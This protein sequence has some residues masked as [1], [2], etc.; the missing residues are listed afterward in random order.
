M[1][2]FERDLGVEQGRIAPSG[3]VPPEGTYV[4]VLGSDV[5]GRAFALMPGDGPYVTQA[6]SPD[7]SVVR[8][9]IRARGPAAGIPAQADSVPGPFALSDGDELTFEVG[10][11]PRTVTFT[12]DLFEDIATATAAEV[13]AA[14]A[15]QV[16]DAVAA[17]VLGFVRLATVATGRDA[18]LEVTGGAANAAL[19]F[20]TAAVTGATWVASLAID[21]ETVSF[22]LQ[23]GRTL[24]T[25]DVGVNASDGATGDLVIALELDGTGGPWEVE[26]PAVYI[27]SIVDE[28]PDSRPILMNRFPY[29]GEVGAPPTTLIRLDIADVD[30]G[31]DAAQGIDATQTQ[32][33]VD[34]VLAYDGG[35]F[36]P[37]FDGAG[38]VEDA[39][40]AGGLTLRLTIERAL[41]F[42]SEQIVPVRVVTR[43]TDGL[44]LDQ[45]YSFTVADTAAPLVDAAQAWTESSIRVRFSEA[46]R[47]SDPAAAD[48]ALNPSNWTVVLLAGPATDRADIA[49][50]AVDLAVV[51]VTPVSAT[52]VDV[53][54]DIPMTPNATY[55]VAAVGVSDVLGNVIA[56]PYHQATFLGFACPPPEGRDFQLWDMLPDLN[57]NEDQTGDLLKFVL[58]V[59][60]VVDL[61]LCRI[62]RLVDIFDPDLAPEGCVDHMLAR[63]GNPFD[64]DLTIA[65]KRKL[66]Q[67]LVELYQ[68][69]G[70]N[71]GIVN[72]IRVILG[73]EVTISTPAFEGLGLGDAEL[74][75]FDD[76]LGEIVDGTFTLGTSDLRTRLS[77][78]ITSPVVLTDEQRDAIVRIVEIMKHA[79]THLIGIEEPVEEEVPDHLELGVS[80]LGGDEWMLH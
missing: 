16:D 35:A 39:T 71:I 30:V 69:K 63:L 44:Q 64:F 70:T 31:G 66:A 47:S 74:G 73:I 11:V 61:L 62:D 79:P 43:T 45:E 57:K 42:S 55:R 50:P 7:G 18:G 34:G 22:D 29:P 38:S 77:F 52:E 68:R 12:E 53:V 37:G 10:G 67:F 33:Y 20:P 21:T 25:S 1:T 5:A 24:D 76:D 41:P 58:C 65:Q 2:P 27:D 13:A 23:P 4:F 26:I 51:S 32:V 17:D 56:P 3:W 59:Q 75:G 36:Q 54:V 28:D 46:I 60:E 8:A 49:G 6:G 72:A 78:L 14:I 48:D 40:V 80:E 19:G 9:T 15:D